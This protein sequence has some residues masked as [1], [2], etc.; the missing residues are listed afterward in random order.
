MSMT[1]TALGEDYWETFSLEDKD[2]E[3]LYNYLLEVEIPLTSQELIGA[4]VDERIQECK[5]EIERQRTTG[6]DLYQPKGTYQVDQKLIFPALDWKHGSIMGMRPGVN[7]AIGDFQVIQVMMDDGSQHEFAASLPDHKLNEPPQL[8]DEFNHLDRATVLKIYSDELLDALEEGLKCSPEFVQIAGRWFPRA[9][10]VDI[11][12]GHL[13]LAEAVLDM[14]GGGPLPTSGLLEQL[15]LNAKANPKLVEF[16]LDLALQEDP[17]FDEVGPAGKVLW[18]LKRLEPPEVLNTPVFLRHVEVEYDRSAL[19]PEMLAL[20][21]ALDDELSPPAGKPAQNSEVIGRLIYPHWQAGTLPLSNRLRNLFPT[22]YEAPL[23]RFILV[24]GETGE[25][26]PGW[27][28]RDKRYVFGLN[29][30][31]EARGIIPGSLIKVRKGPQ[32]GQV[33]VQADN[34]RPSR[35]WVRTVLVGSDGGVVFA[36][37]KQIINTP[38]DD[39]MAIVVSDKKALE[40]SWTGQQK[41]ASQFEKIVVNMVKELAKLNPQSHVHASELYAAI[42]VIRRTPPGPLLW[43][44]ASRSIFTHVGD[45]HYRLSDQEL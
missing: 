9:L 45:Q 22:A 41:D 28:V 8:V 44:L 33:I 23:V 10:L 4:L 24:D 6:G 14:A 2:L 3:F 7:P 19:T 13:N 21:A 32:P 25:Q 43:L 16:S 17:R 36:M 20:E 34:H 37:L 11:N 39:R 42:N 31:Y 18:F 12:A 26:F 27:V 35:E 40:Q 30:W 1:T 29:N 38:I 15:E 5:Q